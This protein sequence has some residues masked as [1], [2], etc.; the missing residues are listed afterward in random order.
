MLFVFVHLR[1]V[2]LSKDRA[3]KM[4]RRVLFAAVA[5]SVAVAITLARRRRQARQDDHDDK[6]TTAA[7]DGSSTKQATDSKTYSYTLGYWNHRGIAEP[8]RYML[9]YSG[10]A[11][12][13]FRY[14]AG[15]PP[16]YSKTLWY[17][18]KEG[19]GMAWP[20]LPYLQQTCLTDGACMTLLCRPAKQTQSLT[21]NESRTHQQQAA[22]WC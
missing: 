15:P 3:T 20:N 8:V 14:Q 2:V 12:R 1:R 4:S 22:Q 5:A 16:H 19:M 18:A 6:H 11:W 13:D 21:P 10:A 9:A 17:S 7:T